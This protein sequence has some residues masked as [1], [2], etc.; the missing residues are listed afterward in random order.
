MQQ[1]HEA[2]EEADEDRLRLLEAKLEALG[3]DPSKRPSGKTWVELAD[4]ANDHADIMDA[5]TAQGLL[6][7]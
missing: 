7:Q 1:V 4:T 6:G 3:D 2:G 5:A